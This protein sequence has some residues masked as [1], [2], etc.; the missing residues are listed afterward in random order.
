[1]QS[2]SD[3]V[4]SF[5]EQIG[6]AIE[7]SRKKRSDQ[8]ISERTKILGHPIS[9]TAI[10]EYRR[11][12]RKVMPVTD[13]LVISAALGVPPVA[14]LFP[15]LPDGQVQLFPALEPA[16]SFD[17]LRWIT[18][19]RETIPSGI[20]ALFDMGSFRPTGYVTGIRGY[21][22]GDENANKDE[23]NNYLGALPMPQFELLKQLRA[24]T[25][26]YEEYRKETNS[27]WDSLNADLPEEVRQGLIQTFK[28]RIEKLNNEMR[29]LE[30]RIKD[31]GGVVK[32]EQVF[33]IDGNRV[34]TVNGDD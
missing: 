5:T 8:W 12:A 21:L 14:L 30:K 2:Y 6:K 34:E 18:G 9:R 13:W 11:G 28:T 19:E 16:N 15:D 10:S 3:W 4:V 27:T 24:L 20:D 1:M 23:V 26:T 17:A 22:R 25:A 33:D 32:E 7:K 31:L 29:D